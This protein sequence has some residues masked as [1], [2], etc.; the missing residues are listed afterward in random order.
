MNDVK[1][2]LSGPAAAAVACVAIVCIAALEGVALWQGI[3]GTQ[4]MAVMAVIAALGGVAVGVKGG[5][6]LRK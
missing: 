1:P 3:D 4:F 6:I 2:R 5:D